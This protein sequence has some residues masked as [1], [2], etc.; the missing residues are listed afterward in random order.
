MMMRKAS[1]AA[2]VAMTAATL[3]LSARPRDA[4]G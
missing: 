4:Y 2:W 1:I 3:A